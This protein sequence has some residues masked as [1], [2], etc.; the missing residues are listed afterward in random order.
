M[1]MVIV[2]VIMLS[3][4]V[5]S[6]SEPEQIRRVNHCP[7]VSLTDLAFARQMLIL[8]ALIFPNRAFTNE[9]GTGQVSNRNSIVSLLS[10]PRPFLSTLCPLATVVIAAGA[11]TLLGGWQ[12]RITVRDSAC[13]K[14]VG[15]VGCHQMNGLMTSKKS[16]TRQ[17]GKWWVSQ[18]G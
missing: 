4:S 18:S 15:V 9:C 6:V 8:S 11:G 2:G 17:K 12:H 13:G 7:G 1:K 5:C 14:A 3:E 16:Q 10:L